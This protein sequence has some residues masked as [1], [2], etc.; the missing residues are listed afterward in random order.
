M[1]KEYTK[2]QIEVTRIEAP[3][4]LAASIDTPSNT[5]DDTYEIEDGSEFH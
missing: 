3:V 1:L 4:L 2:P 5:L